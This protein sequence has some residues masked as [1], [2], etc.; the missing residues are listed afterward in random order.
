M[1]KS[2]NRKQIC[3]IGEIEEALAR[4]QELRLILLSS[5][6]QK[7]EIDHIRELANLASVPIRTTSDASLSRLA[8]TKATTSA[9][10]LLGQDPGL[11]RKEVLNLKGAAWLLVNIAYPGN[12]GFAIRSAEV[13]GADACFID[14]SMLHE[15]KREAL[16]ASMRADR[17]MPVFWDKADQLIKDAANA[18]RRIFSIEDVGTFTPWQVDLTVPALFVIGGERA[19]IPQPILNQSHDIL[20]LPMEGFIPSYNLQAAMSMVM[21]DRLRQLGK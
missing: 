16:R 15:G 14:S 13:S 12:T 18:G 6:A 3:G 8:K 5:S 7:T 10:A 11:S 19:G 21:G 20:R 17:F 4:G 9:L 2:W 1:K